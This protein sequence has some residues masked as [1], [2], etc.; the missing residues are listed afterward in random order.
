MNQVA[1][2]SHEYNQCR[3]KIVKSTTK[4][5]AED[6]TTQISQHK[7]DFLQE[8]QSCTWNDRESQES[9]AKRFSRSVNLLPGI[10][11]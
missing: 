8:L 3:L 4:I 1:L 5:I 7:I 9:C 2:D 11:S 6:T 10:Q